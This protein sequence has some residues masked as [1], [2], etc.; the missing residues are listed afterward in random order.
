MYKGDGQV[1]E[2]YKVFV[3]PSTFTDEPRYMHEKAQDAMTYVRHYGRPDLFI[4]FT[5]IP[6]WIEIQS[7]MYERQKPQDKHAVVARVFIQY[8]IIYSIIII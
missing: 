8:I 2:I 5:C 1:S 3:L 7:S 4:T 6:K